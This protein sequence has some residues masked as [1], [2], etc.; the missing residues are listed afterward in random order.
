MEAR[1]I[2]S[3]KEER[4]AASK[5]LPQP[6]VPDDS[7]AIGTKLVQAVHDALYASKIVSYAQGMELLS[8]ASIGLQLEFEFWGHRDDL[9]WRVHHSREIS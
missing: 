9:A 1:V 2:S 7:A 3:R 6:Q 4:V 8:A 5:I